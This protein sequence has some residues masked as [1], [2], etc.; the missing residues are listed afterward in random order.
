MTARS[1][2]SGLSAFAA[3][4]LLGLPMTARA[5]EPTTA[6]EAHD[7]AQASRERADYYRSL[8]GVGYKAGL[9][10]SSELDADRYD[11]LADELAPSPEMDQS[12]QK[13]REPN[14]PCGAAT[15]PSISC[16]H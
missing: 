5:A 9:V 4:A 11:A 12:A 7:A 6:P 8:G 10:R 1:F 13:V 3:A 14:P 15:K 16:N 2:I